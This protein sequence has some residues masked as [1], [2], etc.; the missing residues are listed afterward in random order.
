MFD[1][2]EKSAGGDPPPRAPPQKPPNDTPPAPPKALAHY[3]KVY[4]GV[5]IGAAK[6]V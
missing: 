1:S 2:T 6:E 4:V 5:D 3:S